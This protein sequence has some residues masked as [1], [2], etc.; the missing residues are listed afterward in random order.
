MNGDE[1]TCSSCGRPAANR[2]EWLG[3]PDTILSRRVNRARSRVR[4][5]QTT[6]QYH[7]AQLS[8]LVLAQRLLTKPERPLLR[9]SSTA[10]MEMESIS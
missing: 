1:F 9:M 3:M 5:N 2:C 4:T 8:S 7:R 6:N 10:K